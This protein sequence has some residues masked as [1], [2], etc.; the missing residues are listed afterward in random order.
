MK[1]CHLKRLNFQIRNKMSKE[2]QTLDNPQNG[3]DFIGDVSG[4]FTA[5]DMKNEAIKFAM[6]CKQ[7]GVFV[8]EYESNT[9]YNE[10]I[11]NEFK[12]NYR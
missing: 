12:Q 1:R 11:Y 7:R 9:H 10:K 3:N 4:S 5:D 2:K 6:W 8:Y